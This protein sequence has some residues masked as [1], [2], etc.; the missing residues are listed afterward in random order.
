MKNDKRTM[1]N[2]IV[3]FEK[4][5]VW[6]LSN[7]DFIIIN[8]VDDITKLHSS[9]DDR[10]VHCAVGHKHIPKE[11]FRND[12]LVIVENGPMNLVI[13]F[14]ISISSKKSYLMSDLRKLEAK[15]IG[16][17]T[18]EKSKIYYSRLASYYDKL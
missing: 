5:Q 13:S 3:H 6:L 11:E 15:F 7:G 1:R 17:L 18:E 4:G 14:D 2:E 9:E 12:N 10:R 8:D 16:S